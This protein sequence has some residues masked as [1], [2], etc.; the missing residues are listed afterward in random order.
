[1]TIKAY[2]LISTQHFT[3]TGGIGSF[4][5]AFR[6]MSAELNWRVTCVLDQSPSGAGRRLMEAS[7]G[8]R[9]VWPTAPLPYTKAE[10]APRFGVAAEIDDRM[11]ENFR[12]A[13]AL[14]LESEGEPD[15][16]LV[17]TPEAIEAPFASPIASTSKVVFYTHHENLLVP[18]ARAS[19]VF[20]PAYNEYLYAIPQ[21]NVIVATQSEFNVERMARLKFTHSPIVLPMPIPDPELLMPYDGMR[22]GVL[23][24]G[25]HEPRKNPKRF[26]E[27]VAA[28]G[29]P[30]KVLTN[31]RGEA[32]FEKTLR[33]AGVNSF[34]IRSELTGQ[35]KADFI[36]SARI[37]FHPASSESYG[38]SA[39]ECLAAGLPT[40]CIE[41][42]EWWRAFEEHG[43]HAVASRKV[44]KV[45]PELY[46]SAIRTDSL[47]WIDHEE[48]VKESWSRFL[49]GRG[50][51]MIKSV[52]PEIWDED[53]LHT[54]VPEPSEYATPEPTD[55][56]KSKAFNSD[57]AVYAPAISA[58]FVKTLEKQRK[59]GEKIAGRFSNE[60]LQFTN[61]N[62][63]L[64]FYPWA[65]YS[66]GQA[67]STGAAA[68]KDSWLTRRPRDRRL[69][70]LGIVAG[71]KCSRERSSSPARRLVRC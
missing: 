64:F 18:P 27:K 71:F 23:F 61:P 53:K 15:L 14:A 38:Y 66:A 35:A 56:S 13:Y 26:A 51:P 5:R 69:C 37:A 33:E 60:D 6:R 70:C 17:N 48:Q 44:A 30:A 59:P 49:S 32:K 1:M 57:V 39:M 42:Y 65:L 20:S 63:R 4:F 12:S 45:L 47:A 68:K 62:T 34:E 67:A 24:I 36:G 3:P 16:V 21:R 52:D 31:K 10:G 22:E 28:A 54:K 2:F 46:R 41:E 8:V 40:V 55:Y 25:R 19:K 43:I 7:A 9:F 58:A 11:V 50:T 29:L